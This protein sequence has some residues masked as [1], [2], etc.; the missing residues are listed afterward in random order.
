MYSLWRCNVL[1]MSEQLSL[2]SLKS[3]FSTSPFQY[4]HLSDEERSLSHLSHDNRYPTDPAS[5]TPALINMFPIPQ[6]ECCVAFKRHKAGISFLLKTFHHLSISKD[7]DA[8]ARPST[9]SPQAALEIFSP[10]S[11]NDPRFYCSAL[12]LLNH[13]IQTTSPLRETYLSTPS[14]PG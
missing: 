1:D 2:N 9:F 10:L 8:V 5:S 3:N 14:S 11:P 4:H 6:L 13:P 12:H 7:K